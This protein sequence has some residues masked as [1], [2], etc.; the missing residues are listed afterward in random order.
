MRYA[1]TFACLALLSGCGHYYA[2]GDCVQGSASGVVYRVTEAPRFQG[3]WGQAF[4]TD[5]WSQPYKLD[6]DIDGQLYVKV[7]CPF[8]LAVEQP[9]N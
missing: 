2:S 3:Y 7:V 5:K 8:S 4:H 6:A 9:K 1:F